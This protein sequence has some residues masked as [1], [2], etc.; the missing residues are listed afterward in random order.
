MQSQNTRVV[1]DEGGWQQTLLVAPP[2]ASAYAGAP[3]QY[4]HRAPSGAWEPYSADQCRAIEQAVAAAPG[5][6][7][8]Q[9]HVGAGLAFELRWGS[10]AESGKM[11]LTRCK[12]GMM[13]VNLA[14]DNTREVRKE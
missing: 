1:R 14:N 10:R 12:T 6:G 11:N 3:P 2:A 9:L 13:Q 8:L 7:T 5:G 4:S